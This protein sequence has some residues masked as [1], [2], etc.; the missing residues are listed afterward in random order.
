MAKGAR[1]GFRPD[2]DLSFAGL[3]LFGLEE[4]RLFALVFRDPPSKPR[5]TGRFTPSYPEKFLGRR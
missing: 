1:Y 4:C 5:H 2:T 3:L